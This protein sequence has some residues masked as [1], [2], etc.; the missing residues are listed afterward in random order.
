MLEPDLT[1]RFHVLLFSKSRFSRKWGKEVNNLNGTAFFIG[2]N[3]AVFC[4]VDGIPDLQV[5]CIYF[6]DD[7]LSETFF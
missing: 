3:S 6:T 7:K 2:Y 4:H 1:V 5:V